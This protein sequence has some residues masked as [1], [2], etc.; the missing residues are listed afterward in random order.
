MEYRRQLNFAM[1]LSV[2]CTG[3]TEEIG[4]FVA[5]LAACLHCCWLVHTIGSFTAFTIIGGLSTKLTACLHIYWQFICIFISS[6]SVLLYWWFIHIELWLALFG[7]WQTGLGELV[8]CS[9]WMGRNLFAL[10]HAHDIF[11]RLLK[12]SLYCTVL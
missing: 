12:F 8:V 2:H 3:S 9:R 6:L 4:N 1:L 7:V 11:V 10:H 5:L